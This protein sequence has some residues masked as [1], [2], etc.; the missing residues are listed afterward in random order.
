MEITEDSKLR[1]VLRKQGYSE[2]VT[3][4]I[5]EWYKKVQS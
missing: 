3:D 1:N 5:A 2:K 4:A